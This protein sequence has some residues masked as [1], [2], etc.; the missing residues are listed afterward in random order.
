G[1]AREAAY[2]DATRAPRAE[3]GAVLSAPAAEV[4][5]PEVSAC[6]AE[7]SAPAAVPS[8]GTG[9]PGA[10]VSR[11]TGAVRARARAPG[12]RG[13]V[14]GRGRSVHCAA[15]RRRGPDVRRAVGVP[16]GHTPPAPRPWRPAR[17]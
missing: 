1:C 9:A 7:M 16:T 6:V 8:S 10:A 15:V 5:V 13:R 4:S 3:A 17:T 12:R 14:P 11:S 2:P